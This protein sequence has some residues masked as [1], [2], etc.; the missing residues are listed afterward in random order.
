MNVQFALKTHCAMNGLHVACSCAGQS[1]KVVH[2]QNKGFSDKM[3]PEYSSRFSESPQTHGLFLSSHENSPLLHV[4]RYLDLGSREPS[5]L[6][7]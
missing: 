7:Q 2:S 3:I 6:S 1:P 4:I 5:T